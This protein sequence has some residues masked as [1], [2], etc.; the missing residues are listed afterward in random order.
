MY[1]QYRQ[2]FLLQTSVKKKQLKKLLIQQTPTLSACADS[3]TNTRKSLFCIF[4]RYLAISFCLFFCTFFVNFQALLANKKKICVSHVTSYMSHVVYV[5]LWPLFTNTQ[6]YGHGDS[7][8]D[9][10]QR[11]ESGKSCIW[12]TLSL[13]TNAASKTATF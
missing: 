1:V 9:P 5:T 3:S 11:A 6:T 7:M 12:E 2:S 13:L 8:T 10:A 4:G